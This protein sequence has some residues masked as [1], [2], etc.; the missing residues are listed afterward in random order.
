MRCYSRLRKYSIWGSIRR[1]QAFEKHT[2]QE[3]SPIKGHFPLL[4][5]KLHYRE[6]SWPQMNYVNIY[7]YDWGK[8]LNF[9]ILNYVYDFIQGLEGSNMFC[10]QLFRSSRPEGFCEKDVLENFPK[11]HRKTSVLE[12]LFNKNIG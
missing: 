3:N 11:I 4:W 8:I 12:S 5:F 1:A 7:V 9:L 6:K 10:L 2:M